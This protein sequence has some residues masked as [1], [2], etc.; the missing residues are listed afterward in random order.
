VFKDSYKNRVFAYS[1]I[2]GTWNSVSYSAN[3]SEIQIV[4]SKGSFLFKDPSENR[5]FAY[6]P[7]TGSWMLTK[8]QANDDDIQFDGN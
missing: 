8:Y 5:I 2:T 7:Y 3:D 1:P 6:S 4:K